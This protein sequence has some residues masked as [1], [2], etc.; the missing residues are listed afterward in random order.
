MTAPTFKHVIP[1]LNARNAAEA[2]E[3]YQKAFGAEIQA[4]HKVPD[5]RLMHGCLM[6]GGQMVFMA[7]EFPEHGGSSPASL[8]GTPVTIH[9]HVD[10]ADALFSRAVE[11]GCQV[12]MPLTDMFWGDRYGVVI[13]PYGHSWSIAHT[14]REVS[15]E[16][17]SQI[18]G[19]MDMSQG[20]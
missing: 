20:C 18:I 9:L 11:A 10:N 7:D 8:G 4:A 13:D 12:R 2:L 16:E 1:H 6:F 5:G 19:S 14:I 3:F 17:L 15:P